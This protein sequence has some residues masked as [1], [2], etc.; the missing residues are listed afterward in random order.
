MD[1]KDPPGVAY[2]ASLQGASQNPAGL[3]LAT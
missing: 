2:S 3:A 1:E